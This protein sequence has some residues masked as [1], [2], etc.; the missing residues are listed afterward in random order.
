M[1]KEFKDYLF[2]KLIVVSKGENPDKE[3]A[4]LLCT[5]LM[6]K[7]GYN[8]VKGNY[9]MDEEVFSFINDSLYYSPAEPFYRGFPES[10]KKL[11]PEELLFN[12][13]LSY[14]KTYGLE[15]FS[16]IQ[17]AL[18]EEGPVEKI[19]LYKRYTTKNIII[20]S[21]EEAKNKLNEIISDM[22]KGTRPLNNENYDLLK[23]YILEYNNIPEIA[24]KNTLIKLLVDTENLSLIDTLKLNEFI[25][26]VDYLNYYKYNNKNLNKLNLK[27][28]DRKLLISILNKLLENSNPDDV[29]YC[30]ERRK[31]WKGILHHLH[32]HNNK[33]NI[34]YEDKIKSDSSK[35]ESLL[36]QGYQLAAMATLHDLK[37]TS[38]VLRNLDY[39]ISKDES[40]LADI[41]T[42]L[43]RFKDEFSPIITIQMILHY[44]G[45]EREEK[46]FV[47]SKFNLMKVHSQTTKEMVA[48][49]TNKLSKPT[50]DVLKAYFTKTFYNGYKDL[51]VGN[52][53]IDPS[54]KKIALPLNSSTSNS[55]VGSLTTGSRMP[56]P[57]GT[58]IRAF[59]YW[60][61]VNDI[62]LSAMLMDKDFC[63]LREMSWRTYG[64]SG[65]NKNGILFSGDQTAGV[66]GGSEY[67]D[68]DLNKIKEYEPNCKYI[69]LN[70]N[71]FSGV[72]F[73]DVFCKAGL[74]V[75][76]SLG[77]GEVY[78]PSTVQTSWLINNKSTSCALF[79][80]DLET[81]EIIWLNVGRDST[82]RVAG[83]ENQTYIKKYVD[84]VNYLNI[85]DLFFAMGNQVKDINECNS[86]K[87]VIVI[88]KYREIETKAII[89][90]PQDIE[91][92]TAYMER[93][94]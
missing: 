23:E 90:T 54:M 78:E 18:I 39:I 10:V 72:N 82:Y 86:E 31:E 91:K 61:R 67:F 22:C 53:Y 88:P 46:Q 89:I 32:Y 7:F 59:T 62:D 19:A 6:V 9:M 17:H 66:E 81:R 20:L 44:C 12:Q 35:F 55:G 75:R 70:N 34:I 74:M 14:Y 29:K 3:N 68:F 25:K 48:S 47:F 38:A 28:K 56:I 4:S 64:R 27:N 2:N 93:K 33:L 79:A 8:V 51:D 21:E 50:V 71:V 30:L 5:A 94:N 63:S 15:D 37:G 24:S 42:H 76:D 52:V 83:E 85:Y 80:I 73:A 11:F 49:K 40:K 36:N 69:V 16:Q 58:I 26:V 60:E 57:K 65:A 84:V 77:S 13:L 43:D 87:D 41:L 1:R 92:I 45:F